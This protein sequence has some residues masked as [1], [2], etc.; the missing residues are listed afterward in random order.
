MSTHVSSLILN[1]NTHLLEQDPYS[2]QL[3]DIPEPE[4]FREIYP[5]TEVPK[6]AFNYRKVPA[7]M[8]ED[9]FITD[10]SFRDGQQSR[11]PY[12]TE[13]MVNIYKMLHRLGGPKGMIRLS[14]FQQN[15]SDP[16]PGSR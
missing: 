12:T 2:Y 3:Q 1:P 13:Q 16:S 4:L 6:I 11:T 9:I 14:Y 8:P 5:Y 7:D 10:T 15:G